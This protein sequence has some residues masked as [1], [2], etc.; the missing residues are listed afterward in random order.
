MSNL[1]GFLKGATA[2]ERGKREFMAILGNPN[3]STEER[4]NAY[5][6]LMDHAGHQ[7]WHWL[8]SQFEQNPGELS[9]R[10]MSKFFTGAGQHCPDRLAKFVTADDG[11]V[12]HSVRSIMAFT[13][14]GGAA[15]FM[16][17]RAVLAMEA[18]GL[19]E[20]LKTFATF[21][22]EVCENKAVNG[23]I[24]RKLF[25]D[26]LRQ[27]LPPDVVEDQEKRSQKLFINRQGN[28]HTNDRPRKASEG[29]R[30]HIPIPSGKF[31]RSADVRP[32]EP[33]DEEGHAAAARVAGTP[34]D[35]ANHALAGL[36]AIQ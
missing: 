20:E 17:H 3:S 4:A 32:D 14:F 28:G 13:E 24:P 5:N 21:V 1:L 35:R 10:V 31:A 33:I 26:R 15:I 34:E 11:I 8:T 18:V 16:T 36:A 30:P 29:H 27:Y 19:T 25:E 22:A 2:H 9:S 6:G 7:D 23:L 12:A